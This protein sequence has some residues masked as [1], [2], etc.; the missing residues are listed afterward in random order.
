MQ[1]RRTE[2]ELIIEVLNALRSVTFDGKAVDA[3]YGWPQQW[4]DL[5]IVTYSL[6]GITDKDRDLNNLVVGYRLTYNIDIWCES[7]ADCLGLYVSI[8]DALSGLGYTCLSQG[9]IYEDRSRH[10]MRVTA[11]GYYDVVL[12]KVR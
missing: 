2:Q 3:Q 12:D 11:D 10:H 9:T 7:P 8:D 1:P 4:N 6:A 5:P